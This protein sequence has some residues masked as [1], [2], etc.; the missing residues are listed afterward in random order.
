MIADE[1]AAAGFANVA[2]DRMRLRITSR[3]A[4]DFASWYLLRTSLALF[5]DGR[6]EAVTSICRRVAEDLTSFLDANS[7]DMPAEAYCVRARRL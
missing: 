5:V 6:E 4:E 1:I 2:I 7:L 3:S